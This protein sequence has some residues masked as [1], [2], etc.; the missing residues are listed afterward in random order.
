MGS[1][2]ES[3]MMIPI[4]DFSSD[5]LVLEEGSEGWK[6]MSKKVR[7]ACESHGCFILMCDKIPKGLCEEML[8]GMKA[9]FDLPEETKRKHTSPKPY[10][11]YNGD[12]P[13]IPL[14]QSFGIDDAPLGDTAHAFTNLMWPQ[15]NPSF[16]YISFLISSFIIIYIY[17]FNNKC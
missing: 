4:L 2:S 8:M 12:C 15:G 7:E 3:E 1:S 10:R 16:W 6:K 17:L 13:I 5:E 9:L 11:S 14:C